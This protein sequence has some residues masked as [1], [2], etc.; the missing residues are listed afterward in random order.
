MEAIVQA[1]MENPIAHCLISFFMALGIV[2]S[3]F[4]VSF[5]VF[6]NYKINQSEGKRIR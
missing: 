5:L 4:V 2:L 3:V 6:I 1:L